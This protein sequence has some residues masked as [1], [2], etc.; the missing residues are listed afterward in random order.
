M[1]K[2]PSSPRNFMRLTLARLQAVSSRKTNS[3]HGFVA[4]MRSVLLHVCHFWIVSSYCTPG[5]AHCHAASAILRHSSRAL[6]VSYTWPVVR[7]VV[8]HVPSLTTAFMN[9]SFAR[10]EL[11]E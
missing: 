11:F 4:L 1:S 8:C 7:Y 10:T 5:S 6:W 9:A 2:L 3:L